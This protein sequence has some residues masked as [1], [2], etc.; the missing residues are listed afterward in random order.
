MRRQKLQVWTVD[1]SRCQHR[2]HHVFVW[3]GARAART[4]HTEN[5]RFLRSGV[6]SRAP[7]APC[8][9]LALTRAPEQTPAHAC[10]YNI[11]KKE[12][13]DRMKFSLFKIVSLVVTVQRLLCAAS[14]P[15][16]SAPHTAATCWRHQDGRSSLVAPA[17]RHSMILTWDRSVPLQ[18]CMYRDMM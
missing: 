3:R 5:V 2:P 4:F 8:F 7:A 9:E 10:N 1:F 18:V 14:D 17:P 15:S 16:S 11:N 12:S 13:K 6:A